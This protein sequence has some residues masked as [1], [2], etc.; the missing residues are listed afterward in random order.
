MFVRLSVQPLVSLTQC[1]L[2]ISLDSEVVRASCANFLSAIVFLL[3]KLVTVFTLP[4]CQNERRI[5]LIV[6]K[7]RKSITL[8]TKYDIITE[9]EARTSIT[10]LASKYSMGKS[11]I[12][13]IIK[14]K[15]KFLKEVTKACPLQS[16]S[17]K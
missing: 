1:A 11:T 15:Q 7:K 13:T 5:K 8:Q 6:T 9:Q 14:D 3:E 4:I 17:Q 12:C 2:L 10:A 16:T